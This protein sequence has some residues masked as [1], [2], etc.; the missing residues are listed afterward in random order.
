LCGASIAP[1][2]DR[3]AIVMQQASSMICF[4]VKRSLSVHQVSCRVSDHSV[5]PNGLQKQSNDAGKSSLRG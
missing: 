5:A 1:I 3:E 2:D 4:D